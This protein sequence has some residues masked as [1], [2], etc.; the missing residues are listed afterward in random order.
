MAVKVVY[1]ILNCFIPSKNFAF[2]SSLLLQHI[3]HCLCQRLLY[4]NYI[5]LLMYTA[6]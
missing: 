1:V 2:S 4:I 3:L 6:N 5:A